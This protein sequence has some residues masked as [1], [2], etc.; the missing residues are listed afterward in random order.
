MASKKHSAV[1]HLLDRD[2]RYHARVVVPVPLRPA[3]GKRELLEPLGPD[4]RD[5][6]R[7]LP[8]A[9]ARMQEQ[10]E[11][12]REEL[13][14]ARPVRIHPGRPM[15]DRSMGTAHYQRELTLDDATRGRGLQIVEPM[16]VDGFKAALTKIASGRF[17][18]AE[19]IATVGWIVESFRSEGVPVQEVGT[20][21]WR[22]RM[23]TLAGVQLE[24]LK[25]S[26]ERDEGEFNGKPAHPALQPPEAKPGDPL[27]TRRLAPDSDMTLTELLQTIL[28]ERKA[29]AQ[30]NYECGVTIRMLDECLGES[31]PVYRITRQDIQTY[32]RM[33]AE[34]PANYTKRF[35]GMTLPDAIKANKARKPPFDSLQAKTINEKWLSKLHSLLGWCVRNDL[36]PDN[37]AVGVKVDA[38]KDKGK[39]PR[40]PFNPD[41]LGRIFGDDFLA[42]QPLGED[43]WAMLIS[44]YSGARASEL[45]QMKLNSIRHERGVLVFVIEEETKTAGSQRIVPVHSRLIEL[46][47]EKRVA[48]LRKAKETH[49][50]PNWHRQAEAA[51]EAK[52][53]K[54]GMM[55]LNHY[56]PRF[57]PKRFNVTYMPKVGIN[58]P[59]KTWHSFRHTFKTGLAR[60]GVSRSVMDDLC[61][62]ADHSAGGVY[63]HETSIEAMKEA[64]EKLQFDGIG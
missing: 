52:A 20:P 30:T 24:A 61:G 46:G 32:K 18:D 12:A 53:A 7:R 5:A 37:P 57:I 40:V 50:F 6:I 58:D 29:T 15:T 11:A 64:I 48:Q 55:M 14:P 35:P 54:G 39:P 43:Q 9:V 51:K 19:A 10:I 2:G 13:K 26:T 22:S 62:H 47:L 38:V 56:Y 28:S 3:I 33:L 17:S 31:K 1:R 8:A 21:E 36:I 45:G 23:R 27:E 59:R 41:D 16:F 60:A 4:R 42:K 25:R 34:A 49:L 63:I 44:L